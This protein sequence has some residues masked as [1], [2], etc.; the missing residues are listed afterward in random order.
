MKLA[1]AGLSAV[2][3]FPTGA[4]PYGLLDMSGTVWEWTRSLWGKEWDKP[5]YGYPCQPGR[6][7]ED[8]SAPREI[9]RVLRG[10]SFDYNRRSAR[11]AYRYRLNP[12]LTYNYVGFRVVV[13]PF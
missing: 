4:S 1:S 7:R 10:G 13:S 12:D 11:C 5:E 3:S 9:L 2:G 6:E 8:L